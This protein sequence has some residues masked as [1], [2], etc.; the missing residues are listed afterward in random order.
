M[1]YV[2]LNTPL[3]MPVVF[4]DHV[5]H[6]DVVPKHL[7]ARS[8]GFVEITLDDRYVHTGTFGRSESL[9]L[10]PHQGDALLL[11]HFLNGNESLLAMCALQQCDYALVE[12]HVI[13]K[14]EQERS[15]T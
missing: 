8:A 5:N 12:Q 11:N 14:I 10:E 6:S 9:N 4:P 13:A 15:H 2:I 1:K 7:T 3:P